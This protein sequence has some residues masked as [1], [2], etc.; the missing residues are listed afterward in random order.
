MNFLHLIYQINVRFKDCSF[1]FCVD[2]R[3]SNRVGSRNI[4]IL[5]RTFFT[6]IFLLVLHKNQ[7]QKKI[8]YLFLLWLLVTFYYIYIYI[9][10]IVWIIHYTVYMLELTEILPCKSSENLYFYWKNCIFWQ[11]SF[12]IN[13]KSPFISSKILYFLKNVSVATL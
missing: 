1:F 2:S 4:V 10:W 13:A 11:M 5:H 3:S 6:E 8:F 7:R 12:K 9:Y